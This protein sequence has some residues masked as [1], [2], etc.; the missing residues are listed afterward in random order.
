[1]LFDNNLVSKWI[2]NGLDGSQITG[3]EV[4]PSAVGFSGFKFTSRPPTL[5]T[6][7]RKEEFV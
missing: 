2:G 1:M 7:L 6:D 5:G 4:L 3:D